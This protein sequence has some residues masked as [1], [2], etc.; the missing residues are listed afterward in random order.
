MK[1]GNGFGMI[2]YTLKCAEGHSFESWF[3]SAD[4]YD[5][6]RGRSLVTCPDCG[7][8]TI[9]KAVMAPQVR[10]AR[11]AAKTDP[12]TPL[13]DGNDPREVALAELRKHVEA[14]SDYVGMNF[15]AEARAIH[16]GTAPERAIY[17]EANPKE[18][19]KLIEDGVPVA[20]LPFVPKARSN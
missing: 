3:Q 18:A 15:A 19:K 7:D 20:P 2:R 9:E 6:L 5:T 10:P 17:G 11:T 12:K 1:E 8:A 13:S 4:A 14:N 16:D